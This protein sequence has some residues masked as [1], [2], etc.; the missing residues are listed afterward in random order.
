[1]IL[2]DANIVLRIIQVGHPHQQPAIDAIAMLRTRDGEQFVS[3][4]Q[5]LREMYTVCTRPVDAPYPGLGLSPDAAMA[6]VE[7]AERQFPPVLENVAAVFSHWKDLVVRYS[8]IGKPAH[9]ARLAA[10][11]IEQGIPRLLTFNESN[12]A[13]FKEITAINPFDV[14][15]APRA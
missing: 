1:M 11:M 14:L 2:V 3:C 12:F 10:L 9:D 15:G 4:E 8:V 5:T 13:R 7:T 6:Q